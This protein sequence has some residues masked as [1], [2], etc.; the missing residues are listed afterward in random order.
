LLGTAVLTAAT[1]CGAGAVE[2]HGSGTASHISSLALPPA[3]YSISVLGNQLVLTSTSSRDICT[4]R[5][6]DPSTM[7]V[8]GVLSLGGSFP[9][10]RLLTFPTD[11]NVDLVVQYSGLSALV[12]TLN[13]KATLGPVLMRMQTWDWTHSGTPVAGDGS[14]WVYG[15]GGLKG[16]ELVEVSASTGRFI[17][18]FYVN[19]G[20]DPDLAVNRLGFWLV[21]NGVWSGNMC[22]PS[23]VA[24]HVAPGSDHLAA[25]FKAGT[26][27]QWFVASSDSVFADVMYRSGPGDSQTI[28]R[29]DD[30]QAHPTYETPARLLPAPSFGGTG[31]VV[32]GSAESGLYTLSELAMTGHTPL[33]IGQCQKGTPVRVVRINPAN[34][35]QS[36][37]A[38]LSASVLARDCSGHLLLAGQAVLYGNDMYLLTDHGE[39]NDF[40]GQNYSTL[41][42]IP[43]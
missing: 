17:H 29:F 32:V 28:Y 36:Y 18:R 24:Y 39:G 10:S 15:H 20:A 41:V 30:E 9:C 33:M 13:S 5:D 7:K 21:N 35:K 14:I 4:T 23:C 19:A 1:V 42:R 12:R 16:P 43:L 25:V 40:I 38:T 8:S 27:I 2:R 26:A 37:V 11:P 3:N 6:I 31:Y 34:G 22:S